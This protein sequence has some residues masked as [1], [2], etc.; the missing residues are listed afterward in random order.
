M[1]RFWSALSLILLT[2]GTLVPSEA[3]CANAHQQSPHAC[4]RHVSRTPEI[5][6][7]CAPRP[8]QQSAIPQLTQ[9]SPV[10]TQLHGN[11]FAT[12][13]SPVPLRTLTH[14][15]ALPP[16]ARQIPPLILRI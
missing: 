6:T 7:C 9:I 15:P 1:K 12:V 5:K 10:A 16:N 14:P 3:L 2:L 11:A 8:A 13:D 4:C